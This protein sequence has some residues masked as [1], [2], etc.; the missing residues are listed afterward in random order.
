[1]P[2]LPITALI[3]PS[4]PLLSTP[5]IEMDI[6]GVSVTVFLLVLI[7][8]AMADTQNDARERAMMQRHECEKM[9]LREQHRQE[10]A[11]TASEHEDEVEAARKECEAAEERIQELEDELEAL[12]EEKKEAVRNLVLAAKDGQLYQNIIVAIVSFTVF[13]IFVAQIQNSPL[14]RRV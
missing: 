14:V 5:P 2:P 4:N 3:A 12:N 6:L 9:A 11:A 1:M 8:A 7:G 10:L 13:L